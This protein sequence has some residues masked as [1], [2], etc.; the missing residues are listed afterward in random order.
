MRIHSFVFIIIIIILSLDVI[1]FWRVV[2]L[3]D[4]PAETA[5]RTRHIA[6]QKSRGDSLED[7]LPPYARYLGSSIGDT[8]MEVNH[9]VGDENS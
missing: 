5:R 3:E 9:I 7:P 8:D 2:V 6:R 1:W 4:L